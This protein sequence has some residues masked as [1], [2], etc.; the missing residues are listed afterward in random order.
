VVTTSSHLFQRVASF[1][2]KHVKEQIRNIEVVLISFREWLHSYVRKFSMAWSQWSISS[3]LF[4]R[5]ASFL[6]CINS[7]DLVDLISE[8]SSLSESGFIPTIWNSARLHGGL[9]FVLISFREWLHSYEKYQVLKLLQ[10]VFGSHLFQR[11]ASFLRETMEKCKI[12]KLLQ[13]LISFREWLHS[14][15]FL[16]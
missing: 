6:L 2:Q 14:Y 12:L 8:F 4:Q 9:Y 16:I 15:R 11:V 1:L 10:G 3:H 5:V 13:V 7:K